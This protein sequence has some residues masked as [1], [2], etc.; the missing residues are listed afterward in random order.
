MVMAG[1]F[2]ACIND[3]EYCFLVRYMRNAYSI[4]DS[5][6]EFF[7]FI[8]IVHERQRQWMK[9]VPSLWQINGYFK[10][11]FGLSGAHIRPMKSQ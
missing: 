9:T 10:F 2:Y 11:Q 6:G 7:F 5:S 8:L 1:Y 3:I 4:Y